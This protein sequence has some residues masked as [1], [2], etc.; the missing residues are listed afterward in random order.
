MRNGVV[1]SKS[2]KRFRVSLSI[3]CVPGGVYNLESISA[4]RQVGFKAACAV[5]PSSLSS[6]PL[7]EVPRV[8][9]YSPTLWKLQI[10]TLGL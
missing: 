8:G 7:F 10:K 9:V 4:A 5:I 6:D 2:S 1:T 3:I